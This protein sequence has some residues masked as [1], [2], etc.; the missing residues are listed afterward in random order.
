MMSY[1]HPNLPRT[2]NYIQLNNNYIQQSVQTIWAVARYDIYIYIY[3]YSIYIY[4]ININILY[5]YI[6]Q[7]I[8]RINR[9]TLHVLSKKFYDFKFQNNWCLF[10][11][12]ILLE[13]VVGLFP[14]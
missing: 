1:I 5:I 9:I 8:Y 10:C 11:I 12:I 7:N 2:H 13:T 14:R 4:I 6:I 3:I